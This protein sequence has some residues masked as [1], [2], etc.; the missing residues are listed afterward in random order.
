MQAASLLIRSNY[1]VQCQSSWAGAAGVEPTHGKHWHHL[2][3][4][5]GF[6]NQSY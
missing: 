5:V 3:L 1:G 6:T 4:R 2:Q